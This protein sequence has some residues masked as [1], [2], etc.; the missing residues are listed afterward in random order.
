MALLPTAGPLT[1]VLLL[2][3]LVL[4][5]RPATAYQQPI[6]QAAA[7]SSSTRHLRAS[8]ALFGGAGRVGLSAVA[9][10]RR[11]RSMLLQDPGRRRGAIGPSLLTRHMETVAS[12]GTGS[13][14]TDSGSAATSAS[15]GT[16]QLNK[17]QSTLTKLGL[18]LYILS[19]C[20]SLPVALLPP[21]LAERFRLID[22]QK[23]EQYALRSGCFCSRWL[24]RLIP[25]ANIRAIPAPFE[26]D[27]KPSI[28]V[29]N[30]TSMLDVFVL[31]AVDKALR[32]KNKRPIKIVYWKGLE[33]NPITKLLFT[34]CGMISVDMADNGNGTANQYDRGSFKKL[35]RDMK[36]AFDEG[37]DVGILPEGQLNPT[38]ERG[39]LPVFGGAYTLA[40]MSRRQIRMMALHGV[41]N[42]WHPDETIGMTPTSRD[43]EVRAYPGGKPFESSEEFVTVFAKIVGH[44]GATGSDLAD[45]DLWLDGTR[46]E[47]IQRK[48]EE[49]EKLE[50]E[51]EEEGE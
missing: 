49:I 33:K 15:P 48:V 10:P 40:R 36:Q 34:Q 16:G 21:A 6:H 46:W 41:Q 23:R 25:F 1:A 20:L 30:H 9:V 42:L 29:C 4:Q 28:W 19:M 13:S 37:Y 2:A 26:D 43:V 5:H 32:G 17:M 39:L 22:R 50:K 11:R 31:L 44:F 45:L 51:L 12:T 24:M 14:D 35:L 27:P 18:M 7:A 8:R 3:V 38:P 47:E